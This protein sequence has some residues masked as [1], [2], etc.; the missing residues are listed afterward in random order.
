MGAFAGAVALRTAAI[1]SAGILLTGP[2]GV[3]ILAGVSALSL[4]GTGVFLI[5]KA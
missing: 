5:V 2:V 3:A 1:Y 4:I